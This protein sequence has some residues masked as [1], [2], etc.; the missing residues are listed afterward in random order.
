MRTTFQVRCV[1]PNGEERCY[2]WVQENGAPLRK[3]ESYQ[4][5]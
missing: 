3:L 4:L 2:D 1:T 5:R